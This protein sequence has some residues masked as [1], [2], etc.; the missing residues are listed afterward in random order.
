MYNSLVQHTPS[1]NVDPYSTRNIHGIDHAILQYYNAKPI[2]QIITDITHTLK[3]HK[4]KNIFGLDTITQK[5]ARLIGSHQPTTFHQIIPPLWMER[6]YQNYTE[7]HASFWEHYI[8]TPTA[9]CNNTR[10]NQFHPNI[11]HMER[12]PYKIWYGPQCAL[13]NNLYSMFIH[14]QNKNTT[15]FRFETDEPN[16]ARIEMLTLAEQTQPDHPTFYK[17]AKKRIQEYIKEVTRDP[18]TPAPYFTY[19][20]DPYLV[21]TDT[22]TQLLTAIVTQAISELAKKNKTNSNITPA[23]IT[24]ITR[25][26]GK[27]HKIKLHISFTQ[28]LPQKVILLFTTKYCFFV[29]PNIVT[30]RIKL[31][32][33]DHTLNSFRQALQE[34][35]LRNIQ[36]IIIYDIIK[37]DKIF[38]IKTLLKQIRAMTAHTE[39]HVISTRLDTH[40]RI[41][42]FKNKF[43]I[44][45]HKTAERKTNIE[46][47]FPSL[48]RTITM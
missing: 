26:I 30:K 19:L 4:V 39:I 40:L 31:I 2:K 9:L 10:H 12:Y 47:E 34:H 22:K 3:S 17:Q 43:N 28:C 25:N 33:I 36:R 29:S 16:T 5:I 24:H 11:H 23:T 45:T 37:T 41:K 15:I 48:F 35:K 6:Q 1:Q 13:K 32:H 46:C 8:T 18:D 14:E 38:I 42:H 20:M 7:K 21:D 27:K 44:H